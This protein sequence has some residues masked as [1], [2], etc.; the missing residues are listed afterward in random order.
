MNVELL[1]QGLACCGN[2]VNGGFDHSFNQWT[3]LGAA[4]CQ[5]QYY[6]LQPCQ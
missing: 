5:A 2:S 1:A 4:M 3:S 6:E